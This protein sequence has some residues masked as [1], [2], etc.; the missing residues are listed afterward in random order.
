MKSLNR[1]S[2]IK[3]FENSNQC[4]FFI[5]DLKGR[6][7]HVNTFFAARTGYEPAHL[8]TISVADVMAKEDKRKCDSAIE[9]CLQQTNGTDTAGPLCLRPNGSWMKI[10]WELAVLRNKDFEPEAIHWI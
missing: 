8:Y 1:Q 7:V 6:F 9:K 4:Y 2:L 3:L 10:C 5:T